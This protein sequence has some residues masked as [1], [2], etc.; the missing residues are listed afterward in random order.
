MNTYEVLLI[1][2]SEKRIRIRAEDGDAALDRARE[3]WE[4]T[5]MIRFTN[6]DVT[7]MDAVLT[8]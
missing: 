7:D 8:D 6:G 3:L 4:R 5:E 1:A 2:R